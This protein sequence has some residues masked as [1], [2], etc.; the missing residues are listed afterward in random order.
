MK[1]ILNLNTYF[2]L[3][4]LIFGT[5]ILFF[6]LYLSLYIYTMQQ[7]KHV[8][9]S[10]F[11][12]YKNEISALAEL[13]SNTHIATI[14]DVTFWDDLVKFT[15][16]KDPKW[17]KRFIGQEFNSYEVDYIGIYDVNGGFISKRATSKIK[18]LNFI[19][20]SIFKEL[21]KTKLTRFYMR[22]P[23]GVVE[24]FGA[25]IHPSN[26]PK[27]SKSLPSGFFFM[28]RKLDAKYLQNLEKISNSEI[29]LEQNRTAPPDEEDVVI[30]SLAL[31]DWKGK[32]ISRLYFKRPF[33]LNFKNT[34]EILTMIIFASIFN[35]LIYL[36][37]SRRWIYN[38]L[39][40]ITRVLETGNE[41]AIVNLKDAPGEFGYIG[42][43]FEENSEHRKQLEIS[44]KKAVESDRLK[45]AFLA[46][47][48]HEIRTPMNAIIGFSDLLQ[49]D[50][51]SDNDKADYLRIIRNSG[52]NLVSIIEDLIEMSKIDANQI[53]P[54]IT[55]VDI[56]KCMAELHDSIK[57]TIPKTKRIEFSLIPNE[58]PSHRNVLTDETK[59]KQVITN[60]LT[61]AIKYTD[62]G[63]VF[64]GYEIDEE[65]GLIKF[66]VKDSGLGIDEK[67]L[68][69]IFDR[70]RR[71]EDDFSVELSGLGLGLAISKAY[72]EILGGTIS[73]RSKVEVGSVFTF[74]IPLNYD[75]TTDSI[76][77]KYNVKCIET[78]SDKTI[79]IAED[80][81]IN[82]L[83]LKKILMM[84]NYNILRAANGQEAVEIVAAN[85]NIDLIFM[86]IKM[87]I[88]DGYQAFEQIK[89]FL[90]HLPVIAQ[91]AHASS[92][93]REKIM[94]AGFSECITKPLDKE[95]VFELLDKVFAKDASFKAF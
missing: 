79:L 17:F 44:K 42:N 18:T 7:E 88:L 51:L 78:D 33:N 25:T 37:F 19:P 49:S 86:D 54:K 84:R 56:N 89:T 80:D 92:E 5:S 69:I 55:G 24:V 21:Y 39:K 31:K 8:Y 65:N 3:L 15:H 30:A 46:N 47:L 1:K 27:K 85:N 59:L 23:E 12:Q 61:N 81:A 58:C 95:K 9:K 64:F 66:T 67:N 63:Y 29:E 74:T 76:S 75:E 4:L 72:V 77:S 11:K 62:N 53:V 87:P 90:P 57:V 35:I 70:F 22:I 38:P 32:E 20:Q 83:L 43:L 2:R 73:V 48:S 50:N 94:Q 60:L 6:L 71:I 34:R 16:T 52:R 13:N 93:D 28:A 68:N 82:Y 40:L 14:V 36:Y 91:T 10:T 41:N 26:D 45:S